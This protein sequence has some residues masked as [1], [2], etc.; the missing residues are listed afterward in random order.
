MTDKIRAFQIFFNENTR[1]L[2]D[3]DFEP[4]DN[5]KNERP[6]W[7]EY[8]PIRNYLSENDL[9]D[10]YYGFLSTNF[11]N[12]T[13]LTGA[14]VKDF[15][16]QAGDADVVTFSPFPCHAACFV[17]VFEQGDFFHEG[18]FDVA[19]HFFQEVDPAVNLEQLVTH[20]RNTVFCNFFFAKPKFWRAWK[21]IF[22]RLF[23]LAETRSSALYSALNREL[24]YSKGDSIADVKPVQMKIFIMERA[25][26]FLLAANTFTTLNFPPFEIP[27]SNDFDGNQPSIVMYDALKVAFSKTGDPYYLHLFKQLRTFALTAVWPGMS[28]R[29]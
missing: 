10:A 8:W 19:A 28:T 11:R 25:V 18:L 2:V 21:N 24:E 1:G 14:R 27:V 5:S 20:S 17:N 15:L 3:R 9:D 16:R 12:K 26:S 4:L 23:E 6:D 22:D 7:F 13:L 29:L